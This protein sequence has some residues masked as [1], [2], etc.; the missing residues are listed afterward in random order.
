MECCVEWIGGGPVIDFVSAGLGTDCAAQFWALAGRRPSNRIA[1]W[2]KA[3]FQPLIGIV[4]RFD[5]SWIAR[6]TSLIAD[7]ALGYCLRLRVNFRITLLTDS[8]AL[9]V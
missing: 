2:F 9:V 7:A 6:Y 8:M 1:N 3:A 5:A 4:Q